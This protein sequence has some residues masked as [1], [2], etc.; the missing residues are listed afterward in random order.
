MLYLGGTRKKPCLDC[1]RGQIASQLKGIRLDIHD[2]KTYPIIEE[3][4]QF[5]MPGTFTEIRFRAKKWQM[6]EL[7]GAC[8]AKQ[9]SFLNLTL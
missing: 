8:H 7:R 2:W 4:G 3:N 1:F 5:L 6:L 9:N